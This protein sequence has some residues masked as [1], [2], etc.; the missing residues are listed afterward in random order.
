MGNPDIKDYINNLDDNLDNN[1]HQVDEKEAQLLMDVLSNP[2]QKEQL[3]EVLLQKWSFEKIM[4]LITNGINSQNTIESLTYYAQ[5]ISSFESVQTFH[6]DEIKL[7]ES[8]NNKIQLRLNEINTELAKQKAKVDNEVDNK[9]VGH[10]TSSWHNE[11][12]PWATENNNIIHGDLSNKLN[13]LSEKDLSDFKWVIDDLKNGLLTPEKIESFAS[14]M[15]ILRLMNGLSKAQIMGVVENVIATKFADK[16]DSPDVQWFK[17]TL[18]AVLDKW[19]VEKF[20]NQVD[21]DLN[22]N[23]KLKWI[24]YDKLFD[25]TTDLTSPESRA[26]INTLFHRDEKMFKQLVVD[27]NDSA[28]KTQAE[29]IIRQYI[30]SSV[31]SADNNPSQTDIMNATITLNESFDVGWLKKPAFIFNRADWSPLWIEKRNERWETELDSTQRPILLQEFTPFFWDAQYGKSVPMEQCL[32]MSLMKDVLGID[33]LKMEWTANVMKELVSVNGQKLSFAEAITSLFNSP[34]FDQIKQAIY[35]LM[36]MLWKDEDS[37]ESA[38]I[39]ANYI[40]LKGDI[41]KFGNYSYKDKDGNNQSISY[42]D[43]LNKFEPWIKIDK[44]T[45]ETTNYKEIFLWLSTENQKKY[46]EK[47]V[48]DWKDAAYT[49]LES[50]KIKSVSSPETLSHETQEM[51]IWDH[52]VTKQWEYYMIDWKPSDG[53]IFV[54]QD[55]KLMKKTLNFNWQSFDDKVIDNK[56][57]IVKQLFDNNKLIYPKNNVPLD[58]DK[59]DLFRYYA[60]ESSGNTEYINPI[61]GLYSITPRNVL[62]DKAI[63][64]MKKTFWSSNFT[65][66]WMKEIFKKGYDDLKWIDMW[67]KKVQYEEILAKWATIVDVNSN[68]WTQSP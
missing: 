17:D 11:V 35:T 62:I 4:K 41:R 26:G 16:K 61:D 49:F 6:D 29:K 12:S 18:S 24:S 64:D 7:I 30:L 52:K 19:L 10:N 5:F 59:E 25:E 33:N 55:G 47:A 36:A 3:Q 37:K 2:E 1:D 14:M 54:E 57:E 28:K 34:L 20:I 46:I 58:K 31:N 50:F 53:I 13:M 43:A 23:D 60:L 45:N 9:D 65:E 51:V 63:A 42:I 56:Q 8:V 67:D 22:K 40:T 38:M 32:T 68:A 27:F 44:N 21:D 15:N 48:Q 39:E 66:K